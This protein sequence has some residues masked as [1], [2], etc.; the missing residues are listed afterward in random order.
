MNKGKLISPVRA[1]AIVVSNMIG[2]GVYTSL[3][4]QAAGVH[5]VLALVFIWITG[6]LVAFCGALTYGE[7]AVRY[8]KS[9]GEYIFLTKIFHP[10]LGFMSGFISMTIGFAAPMAISAIALG[11]YAGNLIPVAPVIIAIVV[12]VSLTVLNTTSFRTGT[13]FNFITA[14]INVSLILTLCIIGFV[15]GHHPDFELSFRQSDFKEIINPAFAVSLVYVS[16]AYSGWNS[17]A[18]ITH[19]VKDPVKNLPSI[20][21]SGTLIVLFLYTLLNFIFLYTVPMQELEGQIDIAFLAAKNIFGQSGGKFVALLISIGLIASINSLLIIGPRVTQAI[22]EDYKL[23]RF[24]GTENKSG[25]PFF[26]TILLTI[27]AL[28]LIG[29]STFE[30]IMT[31]IGFTLSIFTILSVTGVFVIRYRMKNNNKE[32]Y[33][34]FGYPLIPVFFILVEGCMM[35]YVFANRPVQSLIGIGITLIGLVVYFMLL[36]AGKNDAKQNQ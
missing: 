19:Q 12:I 27:V 28:L 3:G 2:T 22:A 5:S 34:T 35:L 10:S 1:T 16:F 14:A 11:T 36:R 24:L 25:S 6:G 31:L 26:A 29:T 9:G 8:P 4:L 30:Q 21:I 7:L 33:H 23:L 20:L 32:L 13:N 18:Y 15:K 17:A